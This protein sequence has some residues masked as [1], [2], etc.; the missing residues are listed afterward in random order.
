MYRL[1]RIL[2]LDVAF[3][4]S[5]TCWL[6]CRYWHVHIDPVYYFELAL[7]VWMVYTADHL[8]DASNI[9]HLASTPRH[10]FHQRYQKSLA[11]VLALVSLLFI[12]LIPSDAGPEMWRN[13]IILFALIMVYLLSL[14]WARKHQYKYVYKELFIAMVYVSGVALIPFSSLE[15]SLNFSD[16][17][18]LIRLFFIA[19]INLLLFSLVEYEVDEKDAHPSVLK[20]FGARWVKQFINIQF[21]LGMGTGLILIFLYPNSRFPE[22]FVLT[23]MEAVLLLV[24]LYRKKL[25]RGELYRVLGD[26]IFLFPLI[27]WLYEAFQRL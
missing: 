1:I 26:G 4:A 8:M 10:R 17:L 3:G 24:Y 27:L 23:C 12:Y 5:F 21:V 25:E 14:V 15:R 11:V 22:L 13:A 7:M 2:S 6:I 20:W 16:Y 18:I 19:H 9:E